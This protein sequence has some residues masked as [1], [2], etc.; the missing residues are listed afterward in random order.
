MRFRARATVRGSA[1]YM[2]GEV[3]A[4]QPELAEAFVRDG[5]AELLEPEAEEEA[6]A[7]EDDGMAAE[8]PPKDKM[9]KKS[10]RKGR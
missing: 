4:F 6:E 7:E 5:H 2:P 3:A 8:R 10:K 1:L 9:V